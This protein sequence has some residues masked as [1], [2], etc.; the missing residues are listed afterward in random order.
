MPFT[1]ILNNEMGLHSFNCNSSDAIYSVFL[2]TGSARVEL[3]LS[4]AHRRLQ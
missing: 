1:F 3:F 2:L 4:E